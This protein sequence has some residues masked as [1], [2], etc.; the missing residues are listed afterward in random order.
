MAVILGIVLAGAPVIGFQY[1]LQNLIERQGQNEVEVSAKRA[2]SLADARIGRVVQS[3]EELAEAGIDSCSGDHLDVLHQ[4]AFTTS[5]LKEL[6]IVGPD[7][8]TF[9]TDLGIPLGPWTVLNPQTGRPGDIL[10]EVLRF[11]FR[12]GNLVRVRRVGPDGIGIAATIPADVL[13]LQVATK[14]G[15][16]N[17]YARLTTRDGTFIGEGGSPPPANAPKRELFAASDQSSRYGITVS[18]SVPKAKIVASNSDIRNIGTVVTG[19][20]SL[21]LFVLALL[22]SRRQ[23]DNPITELRRALEANEFTPYYQPIVD[24]TSARL[25]GAEVLVRWCKPDGTVIP[26]G[27]FI[28]LM[29]QSGLIVDLTRNLMRRACEEMADVYV[30]RPH[31]KISFNLTAQHFMDE[32]VVEEIRD[33]FSRSKIQLSQVVLELTERQPLEN[34]TTTRRVIASLQ[35]LGCQVALDDVGTGHSGLSSILKLG[36]DVIKVDKIFVDSIS[37]ERNSAAIVETL[38][39][40]AHNMRMDIIAEGVENF[41][42]VADLRER[43]VR[44]AQGYVFAPPLPGPLF[45]QLLEASDP[46]PVTSNGQ[47][48]VVHYAHGRIVAA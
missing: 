15:P 9:C 25:L 38:V 26:P 31:L 27:A 8:Q 48:D 6:S 29:E 33:T 35:G 34:L 16:F 41:D 39:D 24:I 36:V 21:A 40:L 47:A 43:G 20:L 4:T 7:G 3:L 2:V 32:T 17:G 10:I 1:W 11:Q 13:M 44:A 18:V 45:L 46:L 42:Q 22:L 30:R 14:G 37:T 28:P 23:Q 12:N 19:V 5:P